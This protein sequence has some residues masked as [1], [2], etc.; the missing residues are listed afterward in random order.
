MPTYDITTITLVISLV[1]LDCTVLL[2]DLQ[3]LVFMTYELVIPYHVL[4]SIHPTFTFN[5][6]AKCPSSF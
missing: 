1:V 5:N 4:S 3:D 2:L 6:R